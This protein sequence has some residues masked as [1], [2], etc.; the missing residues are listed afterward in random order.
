MSFTGVLGVQRLQRLFSD[1]SL[2]KSIEYLSDRLVEII[3]KIIG[4]IIGNTFTTQK[5]KDM[6]LAATT[7]DPTS[8]KKYGEDG[9]DR[10]T[11]SFEGDNR[12]FW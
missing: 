9:I 7:F 2:I 10:F 11:D 1:Q 12:I 6:L 5:I 4:K 3:E 8:P